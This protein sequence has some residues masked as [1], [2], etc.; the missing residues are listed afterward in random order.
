MFNIPTW[1]TFTL[2]FPTI[3]VLYPIVLLVV[4]NKVCDV[5]SP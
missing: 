5:K 2:T 3:M 4:V 1:I